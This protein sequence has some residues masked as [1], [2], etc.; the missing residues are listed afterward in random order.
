MT[1]ACMGPTIAHETLSLDL[2]DLSPPEKSW[3]T[4]S[5]LFTETG[6]LIST[7]VSVFRKC[8]ERIPRNFSI[9]ANQN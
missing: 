1:V 3:I 2:P 8:E 4:S 7:G 6:V 5:S 9:L